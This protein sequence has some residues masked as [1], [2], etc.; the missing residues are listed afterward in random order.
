MKKE[1]SFKPKKT[2]GGLLE[3]NRNRYARA[4]PKRAMY[5]LNYIQRNCD[6]MLLESFHEQGAFS[7]K[8]IK[9]LKES[10]GVGSFCA[11]DLS[12]PVVNHLKDQSLSA[13]A[14]D[15]FHLP[16]RNSAFDLTFHSGLLVC[17][18]NENAKDIV[19][20]QVRTTNKLAFVFVHNELSWVDKLSA[21]FKRVVLRKAIF[22][23]R[24]FTKEEL[25][26]M[27]LG[28]EV[29]FEIY[30]I[31]NALVNFASRHIPFLSEWLKSFKWAAHKIFFNELVLV[32][33]K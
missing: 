31:D 11:S 22:S 24:R 2:W 29:S 21:F 19:R 14:C 9:H 6:A 4:R 26:D 10:L 13:V 23:Y 18:D 15:A 25:E 28:L 20:E 8:D 17:F 32:I 30:Y 16:F 7:G 3:D 5:I 12:I 1:K 27:C 33:K